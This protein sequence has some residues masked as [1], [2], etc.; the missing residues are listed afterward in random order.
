MPGDLSTVYL[1]S[2]ILILVKRL[3]EGGSSIFGDSSLVGFVCCFGLVWC[4][5][6]I[7]W[8]LRY[9]FL[10]RRWWRYLVCSRLSGA[11]RQFSI[12]AWS[13][14]SGWDEWQAGDFQ[15]H[16]RQIRIGPVGTL[17]W[18]EQ[19]CKSITWHTFVRFP[20]VS[21]CKLGAQRDSS[22]NGFDMTLAGTLS[23]Y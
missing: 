4:P 6:S 20:V 18:Q 12:A 5:G 13:A 2:F 3:A 10:P 14:A 16:G 11:V 19:T 23:P 17:V 9:L 8:T 7:G 22:K 21:K 1:A 15:V